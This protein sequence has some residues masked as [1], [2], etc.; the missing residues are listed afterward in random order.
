MRAPARTPR[1]LMVPEN[2]RRTAPSRL[3]FSLAAARARKASAAF[4]VFDAQ[5]RAEILRKHLASLEADNWV[6][7]RRG[8]D[9]D[10]EDYI[11]QASSGDGA[12]P[13]LHPSPSMLHGAGR[14]P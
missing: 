8:G 9:E 5:T 12:A 7:D 10:D 4:K 14:P 13:A 6:E 1:V 3:P 11:Q 2:H